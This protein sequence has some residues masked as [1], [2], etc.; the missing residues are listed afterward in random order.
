MKQGEENHITNTKQKEEPGGTKD[1]L[2]NWTSGTHPR[3]TIG[4]V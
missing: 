1:I 2:Q 4:E 3:G